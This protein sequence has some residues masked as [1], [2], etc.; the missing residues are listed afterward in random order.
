VV[1][2]LVLATGYCILKMLLITSC[3]FSHLTSFSSHLISLVTVRFYVTCS[4]M[5]VRLPTIH[6]ADYCCP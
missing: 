3:P 6:G 1:S 2:D 5:A 4:H